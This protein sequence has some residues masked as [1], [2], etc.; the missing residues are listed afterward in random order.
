MNRHASFFHAPLFKAALLTA[1]T[2]PLTTAC[3]DDD[4]GGSDSLSGVFVSAEHTISLDGCDSPVSVSELG[5]GERFY[6]D[7]P[8][9]DYMFLSTES[10]FGQSAKTLSP[11]EGLDPCPEPE[12]DDDFNIGASFFERDGDAWFTEGIA[13][14]G[15]GQNCTVTKTVMRLEPYTVGEGDDAQSGIRVTRTVSLKSLTTE[16]TDA[17]LDLVDNPPEDLACDSVETLTAMRPAAE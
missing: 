17:C 15:S 12:S 4:D 7:L 9:T 6:V 2:F 8:E 5:D 11:C 1:L 3:G 10:F 14:G 13:A 16:D